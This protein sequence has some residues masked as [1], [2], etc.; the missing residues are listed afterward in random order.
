M[1][2]STI[3]AEPKVAAAVRFGRF[4]FALTRRGL[5][6]LALGT[7]W[8]MPAFFVH[9]LVWGLAAWDA[10]ILLLALADGL[11]LPPA[12]LFEAS[13]RWISAPALGSETEVELSAMGLLMP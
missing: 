7:L 12:R 9:R 1:I 10:L 5:L 3:V 4:P 6:L 8:F 2:A 11:R 13:R